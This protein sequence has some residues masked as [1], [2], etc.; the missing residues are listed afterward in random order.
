MAQPPPLFHPMIEDEERE[1]ETA[2]VSTTGGALPFR[3]MAFPG[4][5]EELIAAV[6]LGSNSFHMVVAR[7]V[8]GGQGF[9]IIDRIRENVR[10][11]AGLDLQGRLTPEAQD[12]A[13]Q[14]L[15]VFG[16]RLGGLSSSHVRAVGTNTLRKA[17]NADAFLVRARQALGHPID[18]IPG[19]EEARLI[20]RGV[21]H[22]LHQ[23]GR[24]L[25]VDIGGGST[26]LIIGEGGNPLDLESR[27]M[28]CV[29]WSNRFFPEG[30]VTRRGREEAV[31]AARLELQACKRRLARQGWDHVVGS[32]GTINAIERVLVANGMGHQITRVGIEQLWRVLI[33][34]RKMDRVELNELPDRRRSV[35]PGG[36]AILDAVFSSL[37]LE[38]MAAA[39]GALREGLLLELLGEMRHEDV[40][41]LTVA[42]IQERF[43]IDVAHG[44]RVEE[45]ALRFLDA[46]SGPWELGNLRERH[47]LSWAARLHEIGV[48]LN[49]SAFHRHGAYIVQHADLPGFSRQDQHA[50]AAL[51][52]NHR[53]NASEARIREVTEIDTR[54]LL[55]LSV[56]LRLATRLHR[57]RS[58]RPLGAIGLS[59]NQEVLLLAIPAS[60]L[61]EHP[62]T[63]AEL[64]AEADQIPGLGFTLTVAEV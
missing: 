25:V 47:L 62:L 44:R 42:R 57:S 59:V 34:A 46:L 27:Q 13:L 3:P 45:T 41:E 48:F 12:R 51:I 22:D 53:G 11:G 56:I 61:A 55:R 26:E 30:R 10:L 35:L 63:R 5:A 14:C 18:I 16:Q 33:G 15:R 58:D 20:Y 8:D 6:D 37:R 36:L 24:R 40:R 2:E 17:K 39:A 7:A 38:Q 64:R 49:H 1:D 28:G 31:T 23:T 9:A 4:R 50:L 19:R 52:L 43:G 54:H 21:S 29:S 60:Y 32:S